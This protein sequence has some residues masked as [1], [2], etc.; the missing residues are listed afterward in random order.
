MN[1]ELLLT[2]YCKTGSRNHSQ[3]LLHH[4]KQIQQTFTTQGT[5]NLL[6]FLPQITEVKE[7]LHILRLSNQR[8]HLQ[9]VTKRQESG[10]QPLTTLGTSVDAG[11]VQPHWTVKHNQI[12]LLP[13]STNSC[14]CCQTGH[15]QGCALIQ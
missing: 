10:M 12:H 9:N 11:R 5:G 4:S 7:H 13:V 1:A 6:N 8:T 3:K 14:C 2:K 15:R